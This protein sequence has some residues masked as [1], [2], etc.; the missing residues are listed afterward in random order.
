MTPVAYAERA[1]FREVQQAIQ[2]A[3][4]LVKRDEAQAWHSQLARRFSAPG[5]LRGKPS[6]GIPSV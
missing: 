2:S 6:V 4:A 1:G 5:I 3:D